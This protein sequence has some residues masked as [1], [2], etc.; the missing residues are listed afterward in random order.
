MKKAFIIT[1][2]L[3]LHES[4]QHFVFTMQYNCLTILNFCFYFQVFFVI[5]NIYIH[6]KYFQKISI[7]FIYLHITKIFFNLQ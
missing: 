5:Y 6:L 7:F 1:T 4:L 3:L 2:L